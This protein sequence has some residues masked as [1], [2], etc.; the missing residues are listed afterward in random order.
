M[1]QAW[2]YRAQEVWLSSVL[3]STR[4]VRGL[5]SGMRQKHSCFFFHGDRLGPTKAVRPKLAR[6]F[7]SCMLSSDAALPAISKHLANAVVALAAGAILAQ[8]R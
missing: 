5:G 4:V 8:P 2:C 1:R 3:Q 7:E 6:I